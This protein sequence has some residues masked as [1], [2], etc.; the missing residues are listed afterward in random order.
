ML[1][2]GLYEHGKRISVLAEQLRDEI[3]AVGNNDFRA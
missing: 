1:R 3:K 2:L